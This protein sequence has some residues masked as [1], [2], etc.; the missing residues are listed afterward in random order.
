MMWKSLNLI[1]KEMTET[2]VVMLFMGLTAIP[3]LMGLAAAPVFG[4]TRLGQG[5]AHLYHPRFFLILDWLFAALLFVLVAKYVVSAWE[6]LNLVRATIVAGSVFLVL[7][8]MI[9]VYA[10][11]ISHHELR[12]LM[13]QAPCPKGNDPSIQIAHE[14]AFSSLP[15][16][17]YA[18]EVGCNWVNFISTNMTP[19]MAAGGG[20]DALPASDV[21]YNKTL[22]KNKDDYYY[23]Y[24]AGTVPIDGV[25]QKVALE[26]GVELWFIKRDQTD[27]SGQV[28]SPQYDN[29]TET[30]YTRMNWNAVEVEV[31]EVPQNVYVPENPSVSSD[32]KIFVNVTN[33]TP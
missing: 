19:K 6:K 28:A 10:T 7:V 15:F 26:D 4:S 27:R 25:P 30:Q 5:F 12:N 13:V 17:V 31:I 33:S 2:D 11:Q 32:I 29:S 16:D 21:Y 3:P 9:F 18:R 1:K 14:S 22:P 20:F 23:V 8:W 24:A